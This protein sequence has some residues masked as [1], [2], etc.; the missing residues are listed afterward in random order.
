MG[1]SW[2]TTVILSRCMDSPES[3]KGIVRRRQPLLNL[4]WQRQLWLTNL[5]RFFE[6]PLLGLSVGLDGYEEFMM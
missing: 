1:F 3:L 2:V 5:D 4:W 6:N